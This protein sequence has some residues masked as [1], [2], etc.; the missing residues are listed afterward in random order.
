MQTLAYATDDTY[1]WL[2]ASAKHCQN[3]CFGA[4]PMWQDLSM[5]H[6]WPGKKLLSICQPGLKEIK[7]IHSQ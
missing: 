3:S 2:S 5:H 4:P 6:D 1:P 7:I